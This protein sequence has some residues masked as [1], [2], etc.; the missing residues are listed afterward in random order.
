MSSKP[1]ASTRKAH[2]Y[3]VVVDDQ[4]NELKLQAWNLDRRM[5]KPRSRS[6]DERP[7]CGRVMGISEGLDAVPVGCVLRE[8]CVFRVTAG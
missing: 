5:P 7:T 4:G 8:P 6:A 1:I 3:V 2:G